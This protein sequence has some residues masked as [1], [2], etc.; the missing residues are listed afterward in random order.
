NVRLPADAILPG[1]TGLRSAFECLNEARYGIVWGAMGAALDAW[2]ATRD[3]ALARAQFGRP[4]ASFQLTQAKLANMAVQIAN[5]F[6][7]ALHLGRLKEVGALEPHQISVG[8][9]SN[10]RA[11]IDVA[12]ECR[13]ML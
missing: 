8:K 2:R 10:V 3:Y 7:L 13:A 11:A 6:L 12:R 9:L 5:G 4:L 1:T